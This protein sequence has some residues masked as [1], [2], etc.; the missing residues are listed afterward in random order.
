MNYLFYASGAI[1]VIGA[2]LVVTRANA[3]HALVSLIV[4]FLAVAS[5]F[6]TLGAPLVAALQIVIYAGAIIVLFVFAVMLLR[7]GKSSTEQ[8]RRWL[9]GVIWVAPLILAALLFVEF[10]GVFLRHSTALSGA[11]IE[12]KSVG[13]SL[14]TDYIIGVELAS[15]LLL[16][17]LVAAFHFGHRP[18]RVAESEDGAEDA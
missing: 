18:E 9:H 3:A 11:L 17:A 6:L 7:L 2:L 10:A 1:A 4:V 12:A 15:F 14:F 13:K 5:V 16:S 8:D